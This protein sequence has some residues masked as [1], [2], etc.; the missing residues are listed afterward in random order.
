MKKFTASDEVWHN[1]LKAHPNHKFMRYDS[2]DQFEDLK[3]IFD[4][5]TAN[6]SSSIGL[7]DTTDARTY[8]VGDSQVKENLNFFDE[9][10]EDGYAFSSQKQAP[11]A[12]ASPFSE[13]SLKGRAEKLVP[14]KRSRVE[15]VNNLDE[16][17]SDR[18]DSMIAVSNKI[19]SVIQQREE[20]QQKEAEQREEK[21]RLEVEK[22]E[23]EKKKNNV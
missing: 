18:N 20:R 5:A 1:Y 22:R 7:G 23:A 4:C 16:L 2:N 12:D 9:S 11:E 21:L 17:N 10:N 13:T 14:R 15:A 6:G 8:S 19:L 3:I